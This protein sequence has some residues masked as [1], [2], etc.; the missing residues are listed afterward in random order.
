MHSRNTRISLLIPAGV[1]AGLCLTASSLNAQSVCLP[2]PRL[3]TTMPMGGQIGTTV[4]ITITGQNFEDVEELSFSTA[5]ITAIPATDSSGLPV[6]NKYTVTI[7]ADCPPGIYEARAL[8]RLGI[9]SCRAFNVGTLP[10]V[11]RT[12]SNTSIEKAMALEL[13]CIC[14][15][16]MTRQAVDFYSF[17]AEKNQ[18]I[19]VD[20]AAKGIDSKLNAV[21]IVADAEGND[22]K[23]ERRG[24]AVDFTAP[25]TATYIV[26][27]HGLTFDGGSY[28]FYRLAL[29]NAEGGQTVARLPSTKAVNSFSWPPAGLKDDAIAAEQEPN[30]SG[31]TAQKIELPCDIS[32]SFF[33]AAD[34][35]TFEF[36]A[37][38]GDV[39]WVEVASERLGLPTDPS[40]LV[41]RVTTDGEEENLT[42]VAEL[43]DIPSPVKISS[44][45]YS[46]DGPPYNAGSSDII[47]KVEIKESGLHRLQIL[48]LFGGTRKD[49]RNVYRMIIRKASPDF[50]IAGWALHMNLRNGDRNALSKPFSLRGGATMPIEV[51]AV[52]RD[53]FD[54]EIQLSM[55]NLPEGVTA[56]GLAIP[57]GKTRGIV[58]LTADQNAPRGLTQA[59][60]YG[61]ATIDGEQ[62]KRTGQVAQMKWPVTNARS[63]IPDPRLLADIPIAVCG[64]EFAP[65]TIA[66][67]E[68][69]VWEVP[70]GGKL[71]I[72][73]VNTR[74][75][76]FSGK[77]MSLKTYGNGFERNPAFDTPLDADTSEAIVD[78]AKTKTKPGDYTIAF[79]GS[80]VAK[81]KYH[82]E[83][84][85]A[86][87]AVVDDAKEKLAAVTAEANSLA[88]SAKAATDENKVALEA[89]SKA[90]AAAQ[91]VAAAAVAAADKKLKAA[92][93]AAAPKDI[94]DIVVSKPIK[95]RVTPATQETSGK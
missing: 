78:L 29:Q 20:C 13:N 77:K 85:D 82:P 49:P 79:Y 62:V 58:L 76:D 6:P 43:S 74:R 10:E 86:A 61:T 4:D 35:D 42:D 15:A 95:I 71:T 27:V 81:Y 57:E 40:V 70:E 45:G 94:V 44:N 31:R 41:Q 46:Y 36:T 8:T 84:V 33:P 21:L 39:W 22:L 30:N 26:K 52:R 48:D 24:G 88:E 7:A 56:T 5:A 19:I 55:D 54:G 72:P 32:G 28:H 1:L 66:A 16:W 91:K 3:M 17:H 67:T 47:G 93:K 64:S 60:F 63:E 75:Y 25:K 53:G 38:K 80:A 68:E 11:T 9:S 23:V 50:A 73:L 12:R 51:A 2:A 90:A 92:A 83:A 59:S 69:K 14:N 18:R 89:D 87:K 37:Q 65:V 34:I